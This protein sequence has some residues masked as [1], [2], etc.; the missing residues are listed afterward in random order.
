VENLLLIR[1]SFEAEVAE[2]QM[3]DFLDQLVAELDSAAKPKR[4]V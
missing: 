4:S 3:V 1:S 2:E